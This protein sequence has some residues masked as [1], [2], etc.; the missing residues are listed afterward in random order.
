M[1]EYSIF[2]RGLLSSG[3]CNRNEI[4]HKGSLGS[5]DDART[6]NTRIAR[7]CA[8]KA[9]DTTLNDEK[10]NWCSIGAGCID[11][12]CFVVT[13]LCNQSEMFVSDL[14]DGQSHYLYL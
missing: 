7:A 11:R 3:D 4:W 1:I 5:E 2:L 12:T 14:G 8:E 9:R 13:A 10:Y 6:S